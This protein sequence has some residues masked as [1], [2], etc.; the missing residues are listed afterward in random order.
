M[1]ATDAFFEKLTRS[2]L[3]APDRLAELRV[4]AAELTP[5]QIAGRLVEQSLLTAW[6]AKRLL[7]GQTAFFLGKYALLDELGRGGMGAVYKARQMP[8]GRIVALKI[9]SDGLV[10]DAAAVARFER[11][12]RA[13]AALNDP[14]VVSAFDAESVGDTH[15]LVMEYV[16][17]Q[18]LADML[19]GCG[20]LPVATACEYISQA[21]LGLEHA[22]ERG[23]VHRDIKPNNLLVTSDAEGRP[24]I[25]VLDLGLARFTNAALADDGLT[26]TG[27]VMGTPDY[28][29]P[30]QARNSRDADIRA[31]IYS[32]GCTLF[33]AL[34]GSLP[35][36][37]QSAVEKL[38]ARN[39]ED[40][41]ALE[42]R[43]PDAPAGLS[44][45]V[46]KMLARDP[47]ARFQT[48]REI[49]R[50]L[51]PFAAGRQLLAVSVPA[52]GDASHGS[53]ASSAPL[54]RQE[55]PGLDRF[56]KAL[57]HEA[58]LDSPADTLTGVDHTVL[59]HASA[60]P[61]SRP[62][63]PG[64]LRGRI[65]ER[66][67]ADRRSRQRAILGTAAVLV[68]ALAAWGWERTGRTRLVIDW[69]AT[70]RE[71]GTLEIDGVAQKIPQQKDIPVVSGAAGKRRLQ[72]KRPGYE[73]VEA[74][75][76]LAR[77]EKRTFRPEWTPTSA[78]IRRDKLDAWRRDAQDWLKTAG[79]Q[80][81]A[82]DDPQLAALRRRFVELRPDF[83]KSPEREPLETLWRELP[84]PL[85]FL[86][87]TIQP[88]AMPA[89]DP[90]LA[91]QQPREFVTGFGDSRFKYFRDAGRLISSPDNSI[92][93]LCQSGHIISFWN[94][95]TGH[96]QFP[97]D[98]VNYFGGYLAF[99]ADGTQAVW[100]SDDLA[101]RSLRDQSTVCLLELE[102]ARAGSIVWTQPTN[103]IA[104]ADRQS[105]E[106]HVFDPQTGKRL[107][108]L[109][110]SSDL[111]PFT[112]LAASPDG[113]WLA[114]VDAPL[115]TRVWQIASGE[116]FDLP[117]GVPPP[118]EWRKPTFLA[119]SPD[120]R[121]IARG[122]VGMPVSYFDLA[123]RRLIRDGYDLPDTSVSMDWN[124]DGIV[125]AVTIDPTAATV[126]N[127][128]E[129]W[130]QIAVT[131]RSQPH[132]RAALTPDGKKLLT[133]GVCGEVQVWD[134]Q[135]GDELVPVPPAI[136]AVAID[137]LGEWVALGINTSSVEIRELPGGAL[138]TT[139]PVVPRPAA[140]CISPDRRFLAVASAID[141]ANA[142]ITVFEN[143]EPHHVPPSP[144]AGEGPGVRGSDVTDSG[145]FEQRRV[146]TELP[147]SCALTFTPDGS[148]LVAADWTHVCGWSTSDW[149]LVFKRTLPVP[150]RGYSMARVAVTSDSAHLIVSAWDDSRGGIV[151]YSL[152]A[153]K[154]KFVNPFGPVHALT[155]AGDPRGVLANHGNQTEWI[156]VE[157][158]KPRRSMI[159]SPN[160]YVYGAA[161]A[162]S[163]SGA[164]FVSASSDGH[165]T[166][167][168]TEL[169]RPERVLSLGGTQL[170]AHEVHFT[171]DG[172]HLITRNSNGTA[173]VLRL[174]SWPPTE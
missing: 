118:A 18:S 53:L 29:A 49:A 59:E 153:G 107:A 86:P 36:T 57:A 125:R 128:T 22:H 113:Q 32:L 147:K 117:T 63:A 64:G 133:S 103:R 144:L 5:R 23:M 116:G 1:T 171:P 138:R 162:T 120:G 34:T 66:T 50:A 151:G 122:T 78:T 130:R 155:A 167:L 3:L 154:Q 76:E 2:H 13:A 43:L 165:L 81:P 73:P 90:V 54:E 123:Q 134:A 9:M 38:M 71:G 132:V 119:F 80:L 152:P 110:G 129:G 58:A 99:N 30:E 68:L 70:E 174:T 135:T 136:T 166:I 95:A 159:V 27:Q 164:T 75:I 85:D 101:V 56:L 31:D 96:M 6:Q 102:A 82:V 109:D 98:P 124:P 39:L 158:G 150:P 148:L 142:A 143:L 106:I 55:N 26:A 104:V 88:S 105:A 25:K 93:A 35:F 10:R 37:G 61:T 139:L 14:H 11:E 44:A 4:A 52:N 20:R 15:F 69:P 161:L 89:L 19:K 127:V 141:Y 145:Q 17:G 172:R 33:R 94:L 24:L 84:A 111:L 79:G 21:A 114:A 42:T 77:G 83:W 173:Y 169:L 121:Q 65:A 97:P 67:R 137:P 40:A 168:E 149:S 92:V 163:P 112:A 87:A 157:T 8:I 131:T 160:V 108:K 12:I 46:A 156:D 91:P 115:H 146:L 140:M 7:A 51:E 74:T 45:V 47:A 170:L 126:W 16:T 41:P 72:F 62:P 48:P 100:L 60:K 28:M